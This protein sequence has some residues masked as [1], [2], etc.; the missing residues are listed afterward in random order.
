MSSSG[1][2]LRPTAAIGFYRQLGRQLLR[3]LLG[4]HTPNYLV[5]TPPS[6]RGQVIRNM[7]TKTTRR[8]SIRDEV[9]LAVLRQIFVSEDYDI[10]RLRRSSDLYRTYEAILAKGTIPLII[11]CGANIGLSSAYFS[12][13]FS[14]AKI[15]ALEPEENNFALAKHNCPANNVEFLLSAVASEDATGELIDPGVGGWGFRVKER[16]GGAIQMISINSILNNAKYKSC[17]P[18]IVKI[19][20]EGF[21]RELF[22][23]NTQWVDKFPLLIIE[24][25]DWMLPREESSRHFLRV[26]SNLNR[27]FVYIGENVFS[28]SNRMT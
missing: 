10:T 26:I 2:S 20:I 24:L 27:D 18:F 9:D 13:K 21:E 5:M 7:R 8:F 23:K 22:S 1:F 4:R 6:S 16:K 11:D 25:H 12:E 28:I 19:D 15:V 17:E 3:D 14:R